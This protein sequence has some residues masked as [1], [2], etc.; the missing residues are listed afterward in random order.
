MSVGCLQLSEATIVYPSIPVKYGD[1]K[2]ESITLWSPEDQVRGPGLGGVGAWM[3]DPNCYQDVCQLVCES[4]M[5]W[6]CGPYKSKIVKAIEE[7]EDPRCS[8][9]DP[10][11]EAELDQ[12]RDGRSSMDD[13]H[14]PSFFIEYCGAE[15]DED[16]ITE[17][18]PGYKMLVAA[19]WNPGEGL[20]KNADGVTQPVGVLPKSVICD[21]GGKPLKLTPEMLE[22]RENLN[23][24]FNFNWNN[25][26]PAYIE[27]LEGDAAWTTKSGKQSWSLGLLPWVD[28]EVP[29]Q[30]MEAEILRVGEHYAIGKC[31]FGGVYIPKGA[32]KH[33]Q[34]IDYCE[35][36]VRIMAKLSFSRKKHPWWVTK[37]TG[38][39]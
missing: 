7:L 14:D 32:V 27:P 33:L 25:P 20:G 37:I 26:Q 31:V 22:Q 39:V 11:H 28:M 30:H 4:G 15:E 24:N 9:S 36:G 1:G 16:T 2:G 5:N 8:I 38:I 34:N 13:L 29:D 35:V 18:N 12:W 23:W 19:G 21:E 10:E 6:D 17:D 3:S